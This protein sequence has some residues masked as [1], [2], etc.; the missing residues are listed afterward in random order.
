MKYMKMLGT[1]Q[2]SE[3]KR[4]HLFVQFICDKHFWYVFLLKAKQDSLV[5]L[6]LRPLTGKP[7]PFGQP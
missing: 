1:G 7:D 5:S 6:V 3:K 4:Q 2:A